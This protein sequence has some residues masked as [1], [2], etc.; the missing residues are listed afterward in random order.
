MGH[1]RLNCPKT[2]ACLSSYIMQ[3]SSPVTHDQTVHKLSVFVCC[4]PFRAPRP[5]IILHA[6]P[7][8]S[9][10]SNPFYTAV[11]RRLISK[12]FNEVVMNF[13][14]GHAFL[15][16]YFMTI[17]TSTV[18]FLSLTSPFPVCSEFLLK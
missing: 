9:K 4:F 7:P 8:S 1:D 10:L 5:F 11:R 17:L 2:Y 13:L 6:L 12:G 3:A 18:H 14:R 16:K 15:Q